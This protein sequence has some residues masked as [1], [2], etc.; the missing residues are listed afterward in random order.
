MIKQTK[1][2]SLVALN[3][4]AKYIMGQQTLGDLSP[5]NKFEILL[6]IL[7]MGAFFPFRSVF[8][9]TPRK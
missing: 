4:L 8:S 2:S 3:M 1:Q 6:H 5:D 7:I 9:G